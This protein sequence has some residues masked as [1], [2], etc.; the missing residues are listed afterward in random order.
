MYPVNI[1]KTTDMSFLFDIPQTPA[2]VIGL[3]LKKNPHAEVDFFLI[4]YNGSMFREHAL[5]IGQQST[6][7]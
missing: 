2:A 7:N 5:A 4:N 1:M 3:F 6:L